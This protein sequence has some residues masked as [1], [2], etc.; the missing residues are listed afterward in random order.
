MASTF[1]QM[2]L[3]ESKPELVAEIV[4][5]VEE[6]GVGEVLRGPPG[7]TFVLVKRNVEQADALAVARCWTSFDR[8]DAHPFSPRLALSLASN[9]CTILAITSRC[10]FT[11]LLRTVS[12]P[13]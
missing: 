6:R 10:F 11:T 12:F 8:F 2:L 4:T 9:D 13:K 5:E 3:S 1:A 7:V